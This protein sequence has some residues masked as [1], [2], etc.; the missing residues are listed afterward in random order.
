MFKR[1]SIQ[2]S[3]LKED[4]HIRKFEGLTKIQVARAIVG[5]DIAVRKSDQ[6]INFP[7]LIVAA[8]AIIG[9]PYIWISAMNKTIEKQNAETEV[10]QSLIYSP[11][12]DLALSTPTLFPW[13]LTPI[14]VQVVVVTPVPELTVT[15]TPVT[16]LSEIYKV[17]YSYYN[18][19][20]GGVNCHSANWDGKHCADTTASG[21]K[22]SDYIGKA[23]AVPPSWYCLGLGYGSILRVLTPAVLAGDYLVIDLCSGCE[24]S[25]WDDGNFRMDFLDT[26]QKLTWAYPVEVVVVFAVQPTVENGRDLVCGGGG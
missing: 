20:L 22:W 15:P 7:G 17:G 1:R 3:P 26:S 21:I 24:S 6:S 8:L 9:I 10:R 18:P 25:N 23:V 4:Y 14:Q 16:Y 13:M 19:E 5:K 11:T 12:P 2:S